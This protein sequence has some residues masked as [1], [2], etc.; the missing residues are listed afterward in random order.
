MNNPLHKTVLIL[1]GTS[2]IAKGLISRFLKR[3]DF[4][5]EWFGRSAKRM[6]SFLDAEQFSG[7]IAIHEQYD[8]FYSTPGG[9]LIN[10]IG[11]GTPDKLKD[12]YTLWFTVLEKY[13]NLC[14]DYL[15]QVNPA[16]LYIDFSSGAVYG[17][18]AAADAHYKIDP[19]RIRTPDYYTLAKL[20]SEAK[21][22]ANPDLNIADIRIFSYFSRYADLNSGYLMTDI[23]KAVRQKT[24][25]KTSG[26]DL[27]RDYISPDD[28]FA[29]INCCIVQ[30]KINTALDAFSRKPVSKKEILSAFRERFELKTEIVSAAASEGSP[31]A[32]ASVY[33]PINRNA[34][35]IGYRPEYSS[36]EGLLIETRA[37]EKD[38][39]PMV[40]T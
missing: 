7:N 25:L 6:K 38:H 18:D 20:Y 1:G 40:Q 15:K 3:P 16:A 10:C 14:L 9:V 27:I 24:V 4:R 28:L 2:H 32:T 29:L 35:S 26:S 34:E 33:V 5:I 37:A 22:R 21:H 31:N 23:L 13:D 36:L 11:A 30:E 39:D 8:D 17:R 19:N 12:D